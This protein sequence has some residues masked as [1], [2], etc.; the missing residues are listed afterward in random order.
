MSSATRNNTNHAN[1]LHSTL[2]RLCPEVRDAYSLLNTQR[3]PDICWQIELDNRTTIKSEKLHKLSC[4]WKKTKSS[5]GLLYLGE[6]L[7]VHVETL[8]KTAC[9]AKNDFGIGGTIVL[10]LA[11]ALFSRRRQLVDVF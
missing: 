8:K 2:V 4:A 1:V 10:S 5:S 3:A 9:S 6:Q 11:T 7:H